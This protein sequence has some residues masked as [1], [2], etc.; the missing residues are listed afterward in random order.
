[1]NFFD[2]KK[3]SVMLV[4]VLLI[5]AVL[6]L[7]VVGT[8]GSQVNT[9]RQYLNSSSG[10][11]AY[12]VAEACLEEASFRIENN[13][14]FVGTNLALGDA[15]CVITVAGGGT[16]TVAVEVSYLDYTRNFQ[17]SI[18]VTTNGQANNAEL[19]NWSEI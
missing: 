3:G 10:K 14:N 7:A 9:S 17:A 12:Y 13:P 2:S 1:M 6:I 15:S 4:M 8:A 18:E 11:Y 5:S 19:L 16:K